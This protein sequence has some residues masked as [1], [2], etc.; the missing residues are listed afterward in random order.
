[1]AASTASTKSCRNV[2]SSGADVLFCHSVGDVCCAWRAGRVDWYTV[3]SA[4][5]RYW[6][7]LSLEHAHPADRIEA[8]SGPGGGEGA[9]AG[10][11]SALHLHVEPRL[12]PGSA[13]F[14]AA[15][16]FSYRVFYQALAAQDSFCGLWNAAC[17]VHPGGACG[18][19]RGG[20]GKRALRNQG[21]GIGSEHHYIPRG[22]TFT[23]W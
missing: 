19:A 5:R 14:A 17:R 2:S 9:R 1:M 18:T 8:G 15:V 20:A 11:G 16:S 12:E 10:T 7:S 6:P 4:E 3:G 23:G 21:P 13:D 22:H